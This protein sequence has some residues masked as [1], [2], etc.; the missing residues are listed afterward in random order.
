MTD[1]EIRQVQCGD[2]EALRRIAYQTGYMGDS[3][4]FYWRHEK[5]FADIW[6]GTYLDHFPETLWVAADEGRP[7]GYLAGCLQTANAPSPAQA[8]VRHMLRSALIIR[9]GTAGFFWRAMIDSFSGIPSGELDDPRWPAH[10]HTNL[11][12]EA[13]GR[14]AG[15]ALMRAW[16]AQLREHG[17]PGCHLGTLAENHDGIA[18]FERMGF[19]RHGEP[20][21]TPGLRSPG[22]GRH[23]VQ[24]MT[25]DL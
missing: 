1:L 5:S 24:L 17:S 20:I 16:F 22:G 2:E 3:P 23:H 25:V 10:L 6:I 19:E 14:G 7:V 21:L 18:F 8:V 15:A 11:L 9:P 4:A 12:P 13:R